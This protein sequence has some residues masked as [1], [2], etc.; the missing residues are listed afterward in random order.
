VFPVAIAS[1][2]LIGPHVGSLP[3]LLRATISTVAITAM[4]RVAVGPLRSRLRARRTL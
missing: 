2:F 3:F 1:G 4:M